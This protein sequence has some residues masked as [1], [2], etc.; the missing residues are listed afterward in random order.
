MHAQLLSLAGQVSDALRKKRIGA[1]TLTIKVKYDDF[2]QITRSMTFEQPLS[3]LEAA[4]E[5]LRELL[6]KTDAGPRRVRLLGVG[7]SNLV[8]GDAVEED[9]QMELFE[10]SK[11]RMDAN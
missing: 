6:S 4:A 5:R 3:S 9:N 8:F 7:V 11:P 10:E 2:T 1:Y